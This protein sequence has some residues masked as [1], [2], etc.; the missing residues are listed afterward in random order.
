[1]GMHCS[2][3]NVQVPTVTKTL[4]AITQY[5]AMWNRLDWDKRRKKSRKLILIKKWRKRYQI[6]SA[7]RNYFRSVPYRWCMSVL[8]MAI[9][10][11]PHLQHRAHCFGVLG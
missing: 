7:K 8:L 1:M 6:S 3:Y 10:N 4:A 5:T 9:V 2:E 11:I